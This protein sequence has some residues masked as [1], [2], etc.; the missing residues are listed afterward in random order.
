M[1]RRVM[2][3]AFVV[4]K[5][6]RSIFGLTNYFAGQP[7]VAGAI[8]S[9]LFGLFLSAC[10]GG[11]G[12]SGPNPDTFPRFVDAPVQGLH[13]Q[14][15][16]L[17]GEIPH[18]SQETDGRGGFNPGDFGTVAFAVGTIAVADNGLTLSQ[19]TSNGFLGFIVHPAGE[20][21]NVVFTP[22]DLRTTLLTDAS[23]VRAG[24]VN[25][26]AVARVLQGFDETPSRNSNGVDID[27]NLILI[28]PGATAG[29]TVTFGS[30]SGQITFQEGGNTNTVAA[31]DG[32][33]AI[34]ITSTDQ[35]GGASL[36]IPLLANAMRTLSMVIADMADE[37]APFIAN[38]TITINNEENAR[39]RLYFARRD[40]Y[41][42]L[43]PVDG[44]S[45]NDIM[46]DSHTGS[47][48]VAVISGVAPTA[49]VQ[50]RYGQISITQ[51]VELNARPALKT[52]DDG[53]RQPPFQIYFTGGKRV[54]LNLDEAKGGNLPLR[55][56]LTS[57]PDLSEYGFSFDESGFLTGTPRQSAFMVNVTL[58]VFDSGGDEANPFAPDLEFQ[59]VSR[60]GEPAYYEI[61]LRGGA[62]SIGTLHFPF[63][64]GNEVSQLKTE[65]HIARIDSGC[66][67][68]DDV[69][70][71]FSANTDCPYLADYAFRGE[72]ILGVM[73]EVGLKSL[74]P[75][76]NTACAGNGGIC[77]AGVEIFT[78]SFRNDSSVA[79]RVL[80]PR[81]AFDSAFASE[82]FTTYIQNSPSPM[83]RPLPAA[84]GGRGRLV[85]SLGPT[86]G[87]DGLD[88]NAATRRFSGGP[89]MTMDMSYPLTMTV[90][91]LNGEGKFATYLFTIKTEEDR[92]PM[93]ASVSFTITAM[94]TTDITF[95]LPTITAEVNREVMYSVIGTL[96]PHMVVEDGELRGP[97]ARIGDFEI[98]YIATDPDEERD[99]NGKLHTADDDT[100]TLKIVVSIDGK[101]SFGE[102][103]PTQRYILNSQ[104]AM[105]NL[106]A[107]DGGNGLLTYTQTGLTMG[108]DFDATELRL[109]GKPTVAGSFVATITVT[110]ADS[111]TADSDKDILVLSIEVENDLTPIF[112]KSAET[113][114]VSLGVLTT[115]IFPTI[116]NMINRA[117][118]YSVDM[119]MSEIPPDMEVDSAMRQL[120]GRPSTAGS[121]TIYYIA[122]DPDE[123]HDPDDDD[124]ATLTIVIF[125]DDAPMFDNREVSAQ[126][127]ILDSQIATLTLP[128][129]TGGNGALTY[130]D[131][132]LPRGIALVENN[133]PELTGTPT[134]I[135]TLFAVTI[136]VSD[137]DR[138]PAESE[139]DTL[140]FSIEVEDD[141]MPMFENNA[142]TVTVSLGVRTTYIFPTIANTINR[143]TMYSV[144]M[145][146][147][148][149]PEGMQVNRAMRQLSGTPS[150]VGSF[151]IAYIATDPDEAHTDADDDT[152]TLT[153]VVF[154]DGEPRF[155]PPSVRSQTYTV[156]T[157][158]TPLTLPVAI[159]GNEPLM[160]SVNGLEGS[161][162]TFTDN[163]PT[164][165]GTPSTDVAS[166]N[167]TYMV[168]DRDG[169]RLSLTFTITVVDLPASP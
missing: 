134:E 65:N 19:Y 68:D 13:Y 130:T 98:Y 167:V 164:I 16:G 124:K 88:F 125:V 102:T 90:T 24:T 139:S 32:N 75:G 133:P 100:A 29:R 4:W 5:N 67:A 146:M 84:D 92:K 22:Y 26:G 160:Y 71:D 27:D 34:T 17:Q 37:I 113:V 48:S 126:R 153:I 64:D 142:E 89:T 104:I 78:I 1:V 53:N 129:V 117:T 45:N 162:L 80:L 47:I 81:P 77:P 166:Y 36:T 120:S 128:G 152:D 109:S 86:V 72:D 25:V 31:N 105:L 41:S 35:Y 62:G 150:T 59:I 21:Q 87:L 61:D 66:Q 121:F 147:S 9:I 73:V 94:L 141:F 93:F 69:T 12:S 91:D 106:P 107:A 3:D 56:E 96:P 145:D 10:G 57:T 6:S 82:V 33:Q 97:P 110:D 144:D 99:V 119:D 158:I 54:S 79:V 58:D 159:D 137:T 148:K 140:T 138:T 20:W 39:T 143:A 23:T 83:T 44:V 111:N 11:A 154:V 168:E 114:T 101:P 169:D 50:F 85:Y 60:E 52:G 70:S 42:I 108:I 15:V 116:T 132:G 103:V 127:Y 118:V 43:F 95:D 46:I 51:F 135:G 156:G 151:T 115:Y 55:Y 155:D 122:T 123:G 165:R 161:E 63:R 149:I 2:K 38:S 157:Q 49:T 131:T 28:H 30:I 136:V 112:A 76:D 163:P 40:S 18:R 7:R 14:P 74:V 8:L